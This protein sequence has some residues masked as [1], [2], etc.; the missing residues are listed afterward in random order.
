MEANKELSCRFWG[1]SSSYRWNQ[2][3]VDIGLF[4]TLDWALIIIIPDAIFT[5]SDITHMSLS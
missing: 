2:P 4:E 1:C 5:T 3:V